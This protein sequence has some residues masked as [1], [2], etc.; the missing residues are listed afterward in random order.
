MGSPTA[1]V[2][3]SSGAAGPS[4]PLVLSANVSVEGRYV[5]QARLSTAGAASARL[6]VKVDYMGPAAS[7]LF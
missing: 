3:A 2:A 4:A 5:L 1:P 7:T 6:Y